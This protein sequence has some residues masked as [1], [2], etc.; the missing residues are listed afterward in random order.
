MNFFLVIFFLV[1]TLRDIPTRAVA[2]DRRKATHKSPPCISTGGLKN[3]FSVN[4]H[5]RNI[6]HLVM[7][8]A[9]WVVHMEPQLFGM[10]HFDGRTWKILATWQLTNATFT[11]FRFASTM[12]CTAH[13]GCF[14]SC[15]KCMHFRHRRQMVIKHL[16]NNECKLL[17]VRGHDDD[18]NT[19][20]KW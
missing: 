1:N 14:R 16:I 20:H 3:V 15:S 5:I 12:L 4:C 6:T 9:P 17:Q 10:W 11:K 8:F 7:M 18:F 19:E 2:T 13:F